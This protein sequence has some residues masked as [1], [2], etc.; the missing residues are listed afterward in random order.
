MGQIERFKWQVALLYDSKYFCGA[1]II[2]PTKIVSAAHCTY[3]ITNFG[4]VQ[5][6]VGS[7]NP[8][9]GGTLKSIL[10]IIEHPDF[11]KPTSLNNDVAVLI[12]KDALTFGDTIG[13]IPLAGKSIA[14]P[15]GKM[16]TVRLSIFFYKKKRY[17]NSANNTFKIHLLICFFTQGFRIR[18][19]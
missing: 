6:R 11:N 5:A 18:F 2:S 13:G 17:Y 4:K 19:D 3:Q 9:Q 16:V 15:P 12:L 1:T 8:N 7:S 14:V 10:K